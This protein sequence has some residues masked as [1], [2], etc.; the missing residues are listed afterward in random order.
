MELGMADTIM[1]EA[2]EDRDG[3]RYCDPRGCF[4]TIYALAFF[5]NALVNFT[6][7]AIAEALPKVE[8]ANALLSEQ[9]GWVLGQCARLVCRALL[10]VLKIFRHEYAT[11]A[12]QLLNALWTMR[13]LNVDSMLVADG[14]DA[15]ELRGVALL[16]LGCLHIFGPMAKSFIPSWA[17]G[18]LD[19]ASV[20]TGIERLRTLYDEDGLYAPLALAVMVIEKFLLKRV[21]SFAP[22]TQE[23]V[24]GIES[25][26]DEFDAR[27]P[28]SFM[29]IMLRIPI[30][31]HYQQTFEA[32]ALVACYRTSPEAQNVAPAI[33]L[34]LTTYNTR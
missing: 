14:V 15:Q 12:W 28:G 2:A 8:R 6:D 30:L 7:N 27:Y 29:G 3:V 24:S 21:L 22:L 10:G 18:R 34:S 17:T 1:P 16:A 11:G 9:P 19:R 23:D 25:K 26:V 33:L 20:S 4:A 32:T 13:G 31:N 5:V